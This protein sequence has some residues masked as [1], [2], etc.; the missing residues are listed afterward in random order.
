[1]VTLEE[2]RKDLP[3]WPDEVISEWLV[4]LS[5]REDTGWPPPTPFT[6]FMVQYPR[7]APACMVA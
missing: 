1:M 7:R 5:N 2:I 6:G 4:Y 3:D